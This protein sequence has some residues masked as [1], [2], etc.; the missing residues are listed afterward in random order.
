[1]D[2]AMKA[3]EAI[4]NARGKLEAQE[5]PAL[6]LLLMV[7]AKRHWELPQIEAAID[8]LIPQRTNYE[9]EP[10]RKAAREI[11]RMVLGE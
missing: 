10:K 11:A 5:M 8:H 2:E 3:A 6:A 1:M 9:V 4:K 7:A